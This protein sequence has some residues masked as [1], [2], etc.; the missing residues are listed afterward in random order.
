MQKIARKIE[1]SRLVTSLLKSAQKMM[2]ELLGRSIRRVLARRLGYQAF[3]QSV[4]RRAVAMFRFSR[5]ST[6]GLAI[7]LLVFGYSSHAN[8]QTESLVDTIRWIN[9]SAAPGDTFDVSFHLRNV[10]TLA[11]IALRFEFDSTLITPLTDTAIGGQITT[12]R[13]TMVRGTQAPPGGDVD[14]LD[15]IYTWE[16]AI[17]GLPNSGTCTF[18]MLDNSILSS[19]P[20]VPV[21]PASLFKPGTG[22]VFR[23]KWMVKP[24]AA[25]QTTAITF[26]NDPNFSASFNTLTDI[27]AR[28]FKRPRF[29][30]GAV[31][32]TSGGG[33]PGPGNNAPS[34]PQPATPLSIGQGDLLTFNVLASDPDGDSLSLLAFNLPPGATF[35]PNNPVRGDAMVQGTFRWTPSFSQTGSFVV[36]FRATDSAGATSPVRNVTIDVVVV[37]RDLLFTTSTADQEPQG[38]VPGAVGVVIPINFVQVQTSYGVQFDFVYDPASFTPTSLE[39]SDRLNGFTI[40]EDLG[41]TPGRLRVVA[42]SLDGEPIGAGVT[43]VL[44]VVVG[45]IP[46]GAT[47]GAHDISFEN[48]FESIN[49]DPNVASVELSTEGGSVFVDFRGDVNLDGRIDVADVVNV[50]GYILGDFTFTFRQF[51]AGDVQTDNFVDVFDLVEIINIIFGNPTTNSVPSGIPAVVELTY[52]PHDG[53]SGSYI[54]SADLR[55]DVA[56]AQFDIKY[57]KSIVSL[58]SPERIGSAAGVNLYYRNNGNGRVTAVLLRNPFQENSKIPAGNGSLLRIPV[59]GLAQD[60]TPSVRL[61]AAKLSDP[62]ANKIEVSGISPLPRSFALEQNYPNPFNASTVIAFSLDEANAA[63][64]ETRLDIFNVLGQKIKTL[65][66][67]ELP[68]QGSFSFTWDGTDNDGNGVASGVYFYRLSIGDK[69]ESRKMVLLK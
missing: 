23:M 44:F 2:N 62:N 28:I 50:V 19:S 33:G 63:R 56:G 46:P 53:P 64:I 49:P 30:A 22:T 24:T 65:H 42:F 5:W 52:D 39:P 32:I 8:A 4:L 6:V 12:E 51:V 37:P 66:N 17:G 58:G 18:L 59:T 7:L 29:Q 15:S 16:V 25:P 21:F 9:A 48:A 60:A 10:D 38:G 34:L 14:P 31:T 68:A 47:P 35:T 1:V 54:L 45:N 26:V 55:D 11:G 36:S 40:Y 61:D 27:R 69:H 43:S 57:N 67:G 13:V 3:D 41:Q 20:G